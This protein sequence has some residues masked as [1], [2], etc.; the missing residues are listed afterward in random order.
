MENQNPHAVISLQHPCHIYRRAVQIH[1]PKKNIY[2]LPWIWMIR[3]IPNRYCYKS[4]HE[5]NPL[6][7]VTY[8]VIHI[9]ENLY[10]AY[11]V[12][13]QSV[14]RKRAIYLSCTFLSSA[15]FHDPGFVLIEVRGLLSCCLI[16]AVMDLFPL[17][18]SLL[19]SF[20]R[21]VLYPLFFSC[22]VSLLLCFP[23]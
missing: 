21:R 23:S 3:V 15:H 9:A 14:S 16:T 5:N 10:V 13:D 6:L 2:V 22:P 12:K 11:S 20:V 8:H 1:K 18:I 19:I 7:K 17:K 4:R